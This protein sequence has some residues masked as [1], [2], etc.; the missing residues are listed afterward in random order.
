MVVLCGVPFFSLATHQNV[1]PLTK[2]RLKNTLEHGWNWAPGIF[3]GAGSLLGGIPGLTGDFL[4]A[5]RAVL[6]GFPHFKAHLD[7]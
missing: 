1:Y 3:P 4:M 5:E 7:A 6:C 2:C